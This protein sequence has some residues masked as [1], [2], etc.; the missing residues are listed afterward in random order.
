MNRSPH[1][2]VVRNPPRPQ[3][4]D[5]SWVTRRIWC[6]VGLGALL[7]CATTVVLYGSC[8]FY[9]AYA[10]RKAKFCV[11]AW[12]DPP[13]ALISGLAAAPALILLWQWKTTQRGQELELMRQAQTASRFLD[14][15]KLLSESK[16]PSLLGGLFALEQVA[17]DFN[18]YQPTVVHTLCAFIRRT[19]PRHCS[20]D[21][22]HGPSDQGPDRQV[23]MVLQSAMKVLGRL[24]P[25]ND[26]S[27]WDLRE[28]DLT[29]LDLRNAKLQRINFAGADLLGVW[30]DGADLT[31]AVLNNADLWRAQLPGAR[32][33]K[34]KLIHT[35]LRSANLA[36]A[37][38]TA[39]EFTG[40]R[41][42]HATMHGAM[43]DGI[44][45]KG[46]TLNQ[47]TSLPATVDREEAGMRLE[48]SDEDAQ[49]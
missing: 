26:D 20:R 18:D 27:E 5:L 47:W 48:P 43:A 32:L 30:F 29:G 25:P 22:H 19:W 42:G 2:P 46:A 11:S 1:K 28:V 4:N 39:A 24:G 6:R 40:A 3:L 21:R 35:D 14:G 44:R 9:W 49:T 41:L 7:S 17:R 8:S 10:N 33:D 31:A 38:L 23:D 37:H 15:M 13:W 36:G 34:A 16:E 12:T 45:L